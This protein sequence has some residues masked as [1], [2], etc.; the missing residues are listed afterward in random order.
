VTGTSGLRDDQRF[1][2]I[3]EWDRAIAT[4]LRG[5]IADEVNHND[6]PRRA[7]RVR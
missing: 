2:L 5:P 1:D 3:A 6:V 4:V 7:A